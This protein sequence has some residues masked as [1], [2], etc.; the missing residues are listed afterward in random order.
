[1][2]TEKPDWKKIKTEYISGDLSYRDLA[3]RY[4][5]PF[6]TLSDRAK[7]ERWV[8]LRAK[9]RDKVVTTACR[10]KQKAQVESL[11]RLKT[12]ADNMVR[13]VEEA[14]GAEFYIDRRDKKDR[15][16][17]PVVDEN[18]RP[19]QDK[20]VD[21]KAFRQMTAALRDM[22]EAVRDLYDIPTQAEKLRQEQEQVK[23]ELER[24]RLEQARQKDAL[25]DRIV[26]SFQGAGEDYSG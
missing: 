9:H 14:S 20:A 23:L 6:R 8:A 17:N 18:Y 7:K 11:V 16:G 21:A 24:Q 26:V 13:V 15:N 10:R 25:D 12:A 5:V 4:N 22:V 19:I 2:G 3:K 1:M